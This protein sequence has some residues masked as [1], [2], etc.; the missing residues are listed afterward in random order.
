MYIILYGFHQ[1]GVKQ[2]WNGG[3]SLKNVE[4]SLF[5]LDTDDMKIELVRCKDLIELVKKNGKHT[6]TNTSEH[7][8]WNKLTSLYWHK[9]VYN[10]EWTL[11]TFNFYDL[12]SKDFGCVL[13]CG[14]DIRIDLS[15]IYKGTSKFNYMDTADKLK[16]VYFCGSDTGS[17]G[18]ISTSG[19]LMGVGYVSTEPDLL[20]ISLSF[21]KFLI[22]DMY[23]DSSLKLV[24]YRFWKEVTESQHMCIYEDSFTGDLNKHLSKVKLSGVLNEDPV[25]TIITAK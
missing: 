10:A 7:I 22:L 6:K 25:K 20:L 8:E 3:H 4:P 23:L 9:T 24:K 5:V 19:T 12:L 13:D 2:I 16:N 21:K 11:I 18:I 15:S 1:F 14:N 17:A